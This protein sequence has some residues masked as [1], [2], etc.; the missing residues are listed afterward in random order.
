MIHPL[1]IRPVL[2]R[3]VLFRLVP[4]LLALGGCTSGSPAEQ[5]CRAQAYSDPDVKDALER[6]NTNLQQVRAPALMEL[7]ALV[8]EKTRLCLG[9]EGLGPRGGVEPVKPY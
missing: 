1:L 2:I 7:D 3:P 8:A 6:S 4:I 5:Q 9:V